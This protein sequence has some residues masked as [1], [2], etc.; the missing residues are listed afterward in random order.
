MHSPEPSWRTFPRGLG[1]EQLVAHADEAASRGDVVAEGNWLIH[2]KRRGHP[3][4]HA[5]LQ[6]IAPQL[7]E[8]VSGGDAAAAALLAGVLLDAH[9][10]L[11]RAFQLFTAAAEA[12]IPEGQ[13]GAGVM[14]TNGIGVAKDTMAAN[15]LFLTAA[16]AGDGYAAH[17][18]A[19]NIYNGDGAAR[20]PR[21]F[22]RWLRLAAEAGIPE[23]R[24]LNGDVLLS[25]DRPADAMYWYL[26][27][28]QS[29][30]A[31]AMFT[32]GCQYRD[33]TGV[34]RDLVQ[35]VRWFLTMLE[36][37][38]G[39]GVHEALQLVPEMSDE[40][41]REAGRLSGHGTDAELLINRR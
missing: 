33:G 16:S 10:H 38:N 23:A 22:F 30:H 25:Q 11:G 5:R 27:A 29:G 24:A 39:D 19:V 12:G 9:S 18:L 36:R 7:E 40:D 17:N 1:T 35:A 20:E 3:Q 15:D 8:L 2:A 13:R 6:Q 41:I 32:A 31:P 21:E 28:A 34:E 14:L 4:G 26:Q 37:G